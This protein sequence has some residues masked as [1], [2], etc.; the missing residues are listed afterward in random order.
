[1][2]SGY[3]AL[4]ALGCFG[5]GLSVGLVVLLLASRGALQFLGALNPWFARVSVA[6]LAA[7]SIALILIPDNG[8]APGMA[9]VPSPSMGAGAAESSS[10]GNMETATEALAA[11]LATK[12]GSDEDWN[13]LAQSY[14]F[15]GRKDDA[16]LA[17][18]HKVSAR[19]S[20]QDSIAATAPVRPMAGSPASTATLGGVAGLLAQAEE[21]R[22]KREFKQAGDLYR[23]VI[24]ANGMTAD[25]WADYADALA[26]AAPNGSLSGEP[27]KA[28]EQALKLDPKHTK[29]L[30]LKASLAHDERRYGDAIATWQTLRTLMPK[31]S[32]DARIIEANLAEDQRLAGLK[33]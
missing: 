27:A 5:L 31:G 30:W 33:D 22:R 17:R 2:T 16:A 20:L 15:L 11:R 24:A 7:I 10:G 21:H 12:G 9:A 32:S 18:Q 26:S 8:S 13:L 19:R 29:A 3:V 14:D 4:I 6:T 23:Q 1:M 25:A 28:I